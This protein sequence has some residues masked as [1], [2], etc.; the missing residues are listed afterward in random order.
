MCR[1]MK[2]VLPVDPAHVNRFLFSRMLD[3][4]S[5]HLRRTKIRKPLRD[6]YQIPG[7]FSID[8]SDEILDMIRPVLSE[9]EMEILE[10]RL[11]V[12]RRLWSI[13]IREKNAARAASKT[14]QL[15]M[16]IHT[17]PRVM[18][19]HVAEYL[20]VGAATMSRRSK[21]IRQKVEESGVLIA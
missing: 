6:E 14:G 17:A 15:K 4:R 12:P 19:S 11:Y 7:D 10:L 16:N 21:S 3:I 1:W 5:K 20:G 8:E 18:D 2:E 13:V 9:D